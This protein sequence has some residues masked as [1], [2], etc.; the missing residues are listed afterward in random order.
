MNKDPRLQRLSSTIDPK[1]LPAGNLVELFEK[2]TGERP[3]KMIYSFLEDGLNVASSITYGEMNSRAKSIAAYLQK[4]HEK[5][6]RALMLFPS[7][8]EFIVSLVGCFYSGIIAVPAY[9]PKKNRLFERFEAIANDCS[10]AVIL[11]TEKIHSDLV[12]NFPGEDVLQNVQY[13]V[14][15]EIADKYADEWEDPDVGSRDIAMLQY[16]SG[17]TGMPNGVILTHENILYNSEFIKQAFGHDENLVGVNWL[18]GFHDMGLIGALLQPL[19]VGGCNYIIPPNVFLMRPQNWLK[20][21]G[22]Y[23]AITAGGPNFA[24][25]YCV[26]RVKDEDLEEIDLST[27]N[28]L[29]SGAEPVRKHTLKKFTDKFKNTGLSEKQFYP[30][31][32]MAESVLIITGGELNDPPLYFHAEVADLLNGLVTGKEYE[33]DA[34]TFVGCGRP[35]AG[36]DIAIVDTRTLDV[37]PGGIIGE[38][39]V[40]GPSVAPGY[41]NQPGKTKETFNASLPDGSGPWLRTG[42]LGFIEEGQLFITGRMKDLIIVRGRNYHPTDIELTVEGAHEAV[43]KGSVAA[44]PVETKKGEQ[45][46]VAAEIKRTFL[47]E[48]NEDEVFAAIRSAVTEDHQLEAAAIVLLRTNTLPKTSSGK[49]QRFECRNQYLEG[50]LHTV[51]SWKQPETEMTLPNRD[52]ELIIAWMKNWIAEKLDIEKDGI[53]ETVPVDKLGLDSVMAVVMAQDAEE[54]FGIE[55]PLDLFLEETTLEKIAKKGRE[56]L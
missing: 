34:A 35:M 40:K 45:L 24:Y 19:Y 23:K 46:A 41:W 11:T 51:G 1:I 48:L 52:E 3:E 7:G 39:W 33:D 16:T 29:F 55:W 9:P 43:N 22:K 20:A 54:E 37:A 27:V 28:P 56:L 8:I 50:T 42:D 47:R 13:A 44:F 5:G 4:H 6:D 17:S 15:E 12:K 30:C 36:T 10:P 53:D 32:G 18:P 2:R 49:I 21:I 26:D 14:Y 25:E 38:I 31:Y